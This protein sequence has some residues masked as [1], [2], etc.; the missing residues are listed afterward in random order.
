MNKTKQILYSAAR[1]AGAF[2]IQHFE[3]MKREKVRYKKNNEFVTYVDHRSEELIVA[4]LKKYFS[5]HNIISEELA[6]RSTGSDYTWYIDPL[7]GTT[8]YSIQN[9]IFAVA[10]AL[11]Y[12]KRIIEGVIYLPYLNAMYYTKEKRG[13]FL[14]DRPI[15]VSKQKNLRQSIIGLSFPHQI[16]GVQQ[17]IGIYKKLRPVLA[18]I[19]I[20]GSASYS[21]CSVASGHIEALVMSG[22]QRPWD[23]HPGLL[24][25]REAGAV[26]SDLRGSMLGEKFPHGLVISNRSIHDKL[27]KKLRS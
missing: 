12:K 21:F 26:S 10:I 17:G 16:K 19:R 9:P 5:V 4:R 8:N 2:Q 23:V 18:N 22:E 25:T 3:K 11:A 20:F 7:D 27:L 14:N 15:H 24:L 6:S 1:A 13:A